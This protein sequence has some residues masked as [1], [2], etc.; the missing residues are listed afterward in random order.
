MTE[1]KIKIMTVLEGLFFYL[2]EQDHLTRKVFIP[3]STPIFHKIIHQ[4]TERKEYQIFF[5][6]LLWQKRIF[7]YY[8]EEIDEALSCLVMSRMINWI[9][10]FSLKDRSYYVVE[11]KLSLCWQ[12]YHQEEEKEYGSL[13]EKL[14][15]DFIAV[16]KEFE[17]VEFE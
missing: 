7:G 16:E 10:C 6:D 13:L 5:S 14:A 9:S 8:C 1:K 11:E 2:D 4:L 17:K 12:K 3:Y 15:L